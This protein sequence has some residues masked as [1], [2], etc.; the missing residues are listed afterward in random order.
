MSRKV[1]EKEDPNLYIFRYTPLNLDQKIEIIQAKLAR[2]GLSRKM[3]YNFKEEGKK[4][5]V[6]YEQLMC[7]TMALQ[8]MLEH[9][10]G[11]G[12]AMVICTAAALELLRCPQ[13][14]T[15]ELAD[16]CIQTGVQYY[17][18]TDQP[19]R[20]TE[21][22]MYKENHM[23]LKEQLETLKKCFVSTEGVH[24]KE[25]LEEVKEDVLWDSTMEESFITEVDLQN[26]FKEMRQFTTG[27]YEDDNGRTVKEE[28][29]IPLQENV[30]KKT[31]GE[32]Q[33]EINV[34]AVAAVLCTEYAS[35]ALFIDIGGR[36]MI[37]F[38]PSRRDNEMSHET[39]NGGFTSFSTQQNLLQFL[40]RR[41]HEV[42][43]R[44]VQISTFK[45]NSSSTTNDYY[46]LMASQDLI[47]SQVA[48]SSGDPGDKS[49]SAKL[50]ERL[51]AEAQLKKMRQGKTFLGILQAKKGKQK[52]FASCL[53]EKWK[54][55][56]TSLISAL[57]HIKPFR[58]HFGFGKK[59]NVFGSPSNCLIAAFETAFRK[60]H[61]YMDKIRTI[62]EVLK[63]DLKFDEDREQH[64][65]EYKNQME[66]FLMFLVSPEFEKDL[67]HIHT[68]LRHLS[69]IEMEP[70]IVF[71]FFLRNIHSTLTRSKSLDDH[72]CLCG[73]GQSDVDSLHFK[74]NGG[75][76]HSND[77][78]NANN[79]GDFLA[80]TM[81]SHAGSE[82][83]IAHSIFHLDFLEERYCKSCHCQDNEG[84][85][86][87]SESPRY[88]NFKLSVNISH[89]RQSK[90]DLY[91]INESKDYNERRSKSGQDVSLNRILKYI[92]STKWQSH[93]PNAP[94]CEVCGA[95]ASVICYSCTWDTV[96]KEKE[97]KIILHEHRRLKTVKKEAPSIRG[98]KDKNRVGLCLCIQCDKSIHS[99]AHR[100]GVS[101]L[102]EFQYQDVSDHSVVVAK[103]CDSCHDS[104]RFDSPFF[105]TNGP[106]Q[107]L[108]TGDLGKTISTIKPLFICKRCYDLALCPPMTTKSMFYEM[109]ESKHFTEILHQSLKKE[110]IDYEKHISAT[111]AAR[112]RDIAQYIERIE[113]EVQKLESGGDAGRYKAAAGQK[114]Y[115]VQMEQKHKDL[116][117]MQERLAKFDMTKRK[118]YRRKIELKKQEIKRRRD[119]MIV[120]RRQAFS[121]RA[122]HIKTSLKRAQESMSNINPCAVSSHVDLT[123]LKPPAVLQVNLDWG[124]LG[125]DEER[126]G[127]FHTD[128]PW[129]LDLLAEDIDLR[130][131][132][133]KVNQDHGNDDVLW[134]TLINQFLA[135][136]TAKELLEVVCAIHANI[137]TATFSKETISKISGC[138][139]IKSGGRMGRR[140]EV[141]EDLQMSLLNQAQ[142]LRSQK[143]PDEYKASRLEARWEM[144]YRLDSLG[145]CWNDEVRKA[146]AELSKDIHKS[147]NQ[148][149]EKSHSTS[150]KMRSFICKRVLDSIDQHSEK[151]KDDGA[152]LRH[153]SLQVHSHRV[154]SVYETYVYDH[155]DRC[156]WY[157]LETE[158]DYKTYYSIETLKHEIKRRH[159]Y[160]VLCFYERVADISESVTMENMNL[161][162]VIMSNKVD[163]VN[164]ML[165][166]EK[167]E[168]MRIK[169]PK[170]MKKKVIEEEEQ[171]GCVMS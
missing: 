76:S 151:I 62:E 56:Y 31:K 113:R 17:Y 22:H 41:M 32:N 23:A 98:A 2:D 81:D 171:G 65:L 60:Y 4:T 91:L 45:H 100:L 69:V 14:I 158:G 38:D 122:P 138:A 123:L 19:A 46:D 25:D 152:A 18:E 44:W 131:V 95:L 140:N 78:D 52:D 97:K 26:I 55:L 101:T 168:K 96:M 106:V 147:A 79:N 8:D 114:D 77:M 143:E 102:Q 141:V 94:E 93:C 67:S 121:W 154:S 59:K 86:V 90:S 73:R 144:R 34:F 82:R 164:Q 16:R 128:A 49:E 125:S 1:T 116:K 118:L 124:A 40:G 111:F 39:P 10:N 50:V 142:R 12:L 57:W 133:G 127:S 30:N 29:G 68:N 6:E 108:E 150:Y 13:Y 156:Q 51:H 99:V 47:A 27:V 43:A 169:L 88:L 103:K 153:A 80:D 9:T 75:G 145:Y 36:R 7:G 70:D 20:Q 146:Y 42:E 104:Q 107:T 74:M 53:V 85:L 119:I 170:K 87:E 110:L 35:F 64:H 136:T 84:Q 137:V 3:I 129:L 105:A 48:F 15:S 130:K 11:P 157:R 92:V 132:F 71:D 72:T 166:V 117:V 28:G 163:R 61:F 5:H 161:G 24:D 165:E 148:H 33:D 135:T 63:E 162:S 112:K 58:L 159:G 109:K 155:E 37:V 149:L 115:K 134:H 83:C 66:N 160:P 54:T 89:L 126:H 120:G 139:Y 21:A 167:G